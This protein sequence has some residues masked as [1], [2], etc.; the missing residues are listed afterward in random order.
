LDDTHRFESRRNDWKVVI[1]AMR[2]SI[3]QTSFFARKR[4]CSHCT[5]GTIQHHRTAS[6]TLSFQQKSVYTMRGDSVLPLF[7]LLLCARRTLGRGGYMLNCTGWVQPFSPST[8]LDLL[9]NTHTLPTVYLRATCSKNKKDQSEAGYTALDLD[10]CILNHNGTLRW[11]DGQVSASSVNRYR[12][13]QGF[14]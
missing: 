14:S 9:S 5:I 13:R 2:D 3:N 4:H 1:P 11:S 10:R 7:M 8:E 12:T 6:S